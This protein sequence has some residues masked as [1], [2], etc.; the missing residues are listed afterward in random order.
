MQDYNKLAVWEKAHL[1]TLEVYRASAVF[2]KDEIYGLT[3]QTRRACSS[4]PA[5]IAEGCGRDGKAELSRFL[6]IASGST[7]ELLYHLRLARDLGY[8]DTGEHTRL[9]DMAAEVKRMLSALS[10]K[11]KLE[12]SK[13]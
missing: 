11:L 10:K 13:L 1:L 3:A 12:L 2:P 7:S 6:H 4:I 9:N 8:M 5:N